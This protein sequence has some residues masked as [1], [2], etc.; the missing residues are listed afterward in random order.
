M[1][2]IL[3]IISCLAAIWGLSAQSISWDNTAVKLKK[4]LF[5]PQWAANAK[6]IGSIDGTAYYAENLNRLQVFDLFG[7]TRFIFF[8]TDGTRL[9]R[10]SDVT[11]SKYEEID[12]GV[13]G[14]RIFVSYST[15]VKKEGRKD[16]KL[17][18]YNPF[19]FEKEETEELFSYYPLG[20]DSYF[21]FTKSENSEFSAFIMVGKNP[22]TGYGTI[23]LKC[24][25]KD[26]NEV[27]THYYDYNGSG[28]PEIGDIF[29]SNT[30]EL[31]FHLIVYE[32]EKKK[33]IVSFDVIEFDAS[34]SKLLSFQL[35]S[36]EMELVDCKVG[37]Y[38]GPHQYL[39][40]CS[41]SEKVFGFKVDFNNGSIDPV[42][43]KEPYEGIWKIEQIVD[44]GNGKYTV[45]LQNR[46]VV[47]IVVYRSGGAGSDRTYLYW[48]RSLQFIG[49]DS[50]NDKVVYD[51]TIGRKYNIFNKR[52]L[53]EPFTTASPYYFAK[54]GKLYVVYNTDPTTNEKES[55]KYE[56][57][58]DRIKVGASKRT[59]NALTKM[60]IF[61]GD[62]SY[63]VKTLVDEKQTKLFFLTRFCNFN[64]QGELIVS[65]GKKKKMF[66]G[67]L[68][69]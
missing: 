40:V 11:D 8:A 29:L 26:F 33:K 28:Y 32:N 22:N 58:S 63:K 41:Q 46:G 16:I 1:K 19:T 62:G 35:H 54:N 45:A 67:K 2:K 49:L 13:V 50:G 38:G 10:E 51:Q 17:D 53:N 65:M 30:G 59:R 55:S 4:Y 48:Y 27:W 37:A 18:L 66:F 21:S 34:D 60:I 3:F 6:Y 5:S 9:V 69:F 12:L 24:F 44:L 31:V 20:K 14:D 52:Y 25:N 68:K 42:F 61:E 57:P 23:I 64:D 7:D 39:C 15:T 56:T 47:E 36:A 43:T